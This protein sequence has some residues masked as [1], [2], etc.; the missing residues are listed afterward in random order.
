MPTVTFSDEPIYEIKDDKLN[1][2]KYSIGLAKFV[3]ECETPLTV[4]IQGQ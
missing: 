2:N 4:G 1:Y 3:S